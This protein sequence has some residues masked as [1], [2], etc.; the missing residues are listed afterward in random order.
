LQSKGNGVNKHIAS[1][2]AALWLCLT[3]LMAAAPAHASDFFIVPGQRIGYVAIG[4]SRASVLRSLN[5]PSKRR[6][7]PGSIEIDTWLGGAL[8]PADAGCTEGKTYYSNYLTVFYKNGRV[9]QIEATSAKFHTK[10][11]LS[12]SSDAGSGWGRQFR[13]RREID[14][15]WTATDDPE[16]SCPAAGHLLFYGDDIAK[17]IAWKQG[18]WGD[19][20]PGPGPSPEAIV[21]TRPGHK[22][23]LNPNDADGYAGTIPDERSPAQMPTGFKMPLR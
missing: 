20:A 18:S 11:G 1:L 6:K 15:T 2:I 22:L 13:H 9:I 17:G 8:Q 16:Y 23:L 7:I 5:R 14:Y 3:I 12:T 10:T 19:L 4:E 21:V